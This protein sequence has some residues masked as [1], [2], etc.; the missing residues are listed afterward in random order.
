MSE[1]SSNELDSKELAARLAKLDERTAALEKHAPQSRQPWW[2]NPVSATLIA[3]CIAAIAPLMAGITG[4][5]QNEREYK[6]AL[7]DQQDHIRQ[8]YLDRVLRPGITEGDA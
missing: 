8:V 1:S 3:A 4:Y 6:R 7:I 2:Q 5:F